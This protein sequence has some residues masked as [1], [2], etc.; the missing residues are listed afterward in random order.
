M[1]EKS[2]EAP[3]I[4]AADS[5]ELLELRGKRSDQ[6]RLL[7]QRGKLMSSY[8]APS[9]QQRDV[10]VRAMSCAGENDLT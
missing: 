2:D 1:V 7:P 3:K 9:Q 5:L 8:S 10:Q 4:Q 6:A